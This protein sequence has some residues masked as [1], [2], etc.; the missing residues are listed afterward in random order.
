MLEFDFAYAMNWQI[1]AYNYI[2]P[3]G[4]CVYKYENVNFALWNAKNSVYV[5][6]HNKQRWHIYH[7]NYGNDSP[8]TDKNMIILSD[9]IWLLHPVLL[10][11]TWVFAETAT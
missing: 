3:V 6:H 2:I 7:Q 11:I 8:L 10:K 1:K 9:Q 5:C 4:T